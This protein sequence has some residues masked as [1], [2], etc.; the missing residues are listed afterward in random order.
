M[1]NPLRSLLKVADGPANYLV[2]FSSRYSYVY[3]ETPKVACSSIKRM[4]QIAEVDGDLS[5][6]S[7]DVHDREL[8]PLKPMYTDPAAF[9]K[10]FDDPGT[11]R[12]CFVRNPYSRALSCYL[13]K[14]VQNEIARPRFL[15]QLGFSPDSHVTFR[16]FLLA[17]RD[18]TEAEC[19]P[20]W[21]PQN[22]LLNPHAMKY[23]FIGRFE[24]LDTHVQLV[25]ERLGFAQYAGQLVA[26]HR[27]SAADKVR[28]HYSRAE[29]DLV[30]QIYAGD[31]EAF[32]YGWAPDIL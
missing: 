6:L 20:H 11:F 4:L 24:F 1:E 3:V 18:Q 14:F 32:G 28:Q 7:D 21:A 10:L 5:R 9:N 19:N 15:P 30:Q 22:F 16:D 23:S 12:F 8:S 25:A 29:I 26:P 17:V 2:N 31:F 13:D 27:T